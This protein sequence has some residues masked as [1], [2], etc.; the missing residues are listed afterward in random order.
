MVGC[1]V[2]Q[3]LLGLGDKSD[4]LAASSL[5]ALA[6]LVP[7]LGR[8]VVVGGKTKNYFRRGMPKVGRILLFTKYKIFYRT[9][10]FEPQHEKKYLLTY[11]CTGTVAQW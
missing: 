11:A 6:D 7:I 5:R 4:E 10:I 2:F 9:G 8:D 3:I 1:I